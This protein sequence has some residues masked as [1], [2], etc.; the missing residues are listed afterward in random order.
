VTVCAILLAAD[1]AARAYH[2]F[3]ALDRSHDRR[4]VELLDRLTSGLDD[5]RAIL[6]ADLNWQVLNGLSY[7]VKTL[8]PEIA[9]TRLADVL[10]YTPAL[11][12]DNRTAG[13]EV[14]VTERTRPTLHEAFGPLLR[15]EPD[16]HLPPAGLSSALQQLDPGTRY[17]LCVLKP[18][19]DLAIDAADLARALRILGGGRSIVLPEGDYAALAGVLGAA[20]ATAIGSLLPFRKE[21]DLAGVPVEI[22]MDSWLT[23]DT[24]RRMGFGHVVA[25]RQ[26][27][28]IV[29]RG[30]SFVAFDNRGRA[31]RTI[32]DGNVYAPERRYVVSLALDP[33][34]VASAHP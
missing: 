3:P 5:Q 7:Y 20:P 29:E 16:D 34:R 33:Q 27:T 19:R 23:A 11:V 32:Y 15:V 26:H 30:V 31:V 17:V 13:R 24:I 21:L 18:S 8:R 9:V 10:S 1:V 28:L 2:D 22:R 4:P 12:A 25:A 6:I 14:V